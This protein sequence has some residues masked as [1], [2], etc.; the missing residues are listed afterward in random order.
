MPLS[1]LVRKF[2]NGFN[3]TDDERNAVKAVPVRAADI[4]A[5]QDIVREGD[6]PTRSCFIVEGITCSYKVVGEG[7]RQ[8]VNFHIA[9][10]APDLQSL[11]LS[12][13]D[14]SI[15]TITPCKVGFVEHEALAELCT[16][17]PRIAAA[18]WRETLTDAAIF[19]EWIAS[20]GRRP[21]YSRIAHL[22]CEMFVRF[23]AAGLADG[24]SIPFPITQSEIGDAQGLSSVHVNRSL[25]T[26]RAEKLITLGSGTLKILDWEGLRHAGDFD[27]TYL[28][29]HEERSHA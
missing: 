3:L 6:R 11:H 8:I 4:R 16:R 1:P 20:I 22:L 2:A 24:Y 18:L 25:Q 15:A 28:N 13:V 14:V 29:L 7:S 23:R 27:P 19:R 5:D 10:D 12:V 21:A 9:G 26:L 17:S